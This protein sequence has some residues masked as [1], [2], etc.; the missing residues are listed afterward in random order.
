MCAGATIVLIGTAPIG[1]F[2]F[3]PLTLVSFGL[4]F[5]F[6]VYVARRRPEGEILALATLWF[7]TIG[8]F[9][10]LW[11]VGISYAYGWPGTL[12]GYLGLLGTT[13]AILGA[14]LKVT[15]WHREPTR[16]SPARPFERAAWLLG[17]GSFALLL[18]GAMYY[19]GLSSGGYAQLLW[20]ALLIIVALWLHLFAW[21]TLFAATTNGFN[22]GM[23]TRRL[24]EGRLAWTASVLSFVAAVFLVPFFIWESR[25]SLFALV[26]LVPA[27]PY[28]PAVFAPVV[29]C[30][31]F[32][33]NG[34]SRFV[35][36]GWPRKIVRTGVLA[37]TVAAAVGLAGFLASY[38]QIPMTSEAYWWTV[39]PFPA[40]S[41]AIGY[42]LVF[43]GWRRG[44]HQEQEDS[45][46]RPSRNAELPESP[47]AA[48]LIPPNGDLRSMHRLGS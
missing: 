39:L 34:Y 15:T 32:I 1:W 11:I 26:S 42:A 6:G 17:A 43:L 21:I 30:H 3:F 12:V 41:T 46:E 20:S 24:N 28:H 8:G 10:F 48:D 5:L 4:V 47:I 7:A 44:T 36:E 37:L 19:P 45:D 23:G 31:A 22:E 9:P 33:F 2:L 27:F 13:I 25:P 29:L 40:G 35:P 38:E 18:A 16:L 14:A